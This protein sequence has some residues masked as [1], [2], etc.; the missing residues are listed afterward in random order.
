[1]YPC[2]CREDGLECT[3]TVTVETDICASCLYNCGQPKKEAK[4]FD[5]GKPEIHYILAMPGLDEVAKVGTHGAKKYGQWN[6]RAGMPWMKLL[7]SC[8]RHLTSFILGEDKDPESGLSHLAHLIYD[9]LM[10]LGYVKEHP[11]LDDRYKAAK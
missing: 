2:P 4:H 6:Y 5:D 7:G 1:M 11:N 8:S 9:A 3:C 10:L